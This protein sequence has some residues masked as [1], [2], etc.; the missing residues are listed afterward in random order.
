M[1]RV[2]AEHVPDGNGAHLLLVGPQL[3]E[4]SDDPEDAGVLAELREAWQELPAAPRANI[5]IV[6]L[7]MQDQEENSVM[8]N[9][10]QRR[11]D[12]AV[13]K[14]LAEGFGLT[15]AEAM[16]KSCG[17]VAS[18]VGGIQDQIEH[19]E[20]GLLVDDPEDVASFGS[21]ITRLLEDRDFA[22]RLGTR[23]RERVLDNF[24]APL[25][26]ERH[27][28]LATGLLNGGGDGSNE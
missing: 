16:W 3:G 26:L 1:L 5:H 12:V 24:L 13:Q 25:C 18:R 28:S 8:V 15:V 23:A 11:A 17:M 20:S 10:L 7:P 21:A 9:A 27:L 22:S 2:F 14:S 19:E 6:C 4:V